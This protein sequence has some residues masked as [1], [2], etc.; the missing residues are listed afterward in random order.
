MFTNNRNGRHW[1][2]NLTSPITVA[3]LLAVGTL[4]DEVRRS[5]LNADVR[6][7]EENFR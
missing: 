7:Y 3:Q 2:Y 1:A 5:E 4:V 6:D